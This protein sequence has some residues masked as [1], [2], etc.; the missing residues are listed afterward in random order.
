MSGADVFVGA[1]SEEQDKYSL[2]RNTGN[3]ITNPISIK[4]SCCFLWRDLVF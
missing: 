1:G 3:T 4:R 2:Y